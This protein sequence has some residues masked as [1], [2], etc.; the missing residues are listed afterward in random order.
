[1]KKKLI[2]LLLLTVSC[3]YA[4]YSQEIVIKKGI[5]QDLMMVNDSI[6]ESFA[7][8]LPTT[9]D[10]SVNWPV[11][12]PIDMKGRAR[13]VLSMFMEAAEEQGYIL[14]ASNNIHDSLS[15]TD[16][17]LI[18]SRLINKVNSMLA[19]HKERTYTAGFAGGAKFAALVPSIIKPVEGVLSCG[20]ALPYMELIDQKKPFMFIGI[21]GRSDFNYTEMIAATG[22]SLT[23]QKDVGRQVFFDNYLMTFDGGQEW[24][25]KRYLKKGLEMFTLKAMKKGV[26]QKDS[27]YITHIFNKEYSEINDLISKNN[28]SGAVDL[29]DE[30]LLKFKGL[31]DLNQLKNRKKA[32]AKDKRYILQNRKERKYFTREYFIRGEYGYNLNDDVLTL[33]YNNLGWWNY[34]MSVIKKHLASPEPL[35]RE[36]GERLLGFLNALIE[37]NIDLELFQDPV[38]EEALSFLWM[39]KTIT[40]PKEYDNY[41]S[42]ISDS[43]KHEDFGTALFYL[44]ELLKNG[45]TNTTELYALEHT[46]LFR[47][48]PEF[49]NIVAKYLQGARYDI[50]E[51]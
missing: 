20:S 11:L 32:L 16:N 3:L 17:M 42:I 9:Y 23:T 48:T 12:L 46:A 4:S 7:I 43:A 30:M 35:E 47:I 14:A 41:L 45:Y 27:A 40:A 22:R 39:V 13:Q 29:A 15:I 33:N 44:E 19:I 1:M 10:S 50:I 31:V 8:Y 25:D 2:L 38:N 6:G 49:N 24:P 34:Q 5:V 21:V 18:M 26:V 37:D 51:E 36:M 28:I